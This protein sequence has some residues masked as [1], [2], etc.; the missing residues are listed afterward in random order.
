MANTTR[1]LGSELKV[2]DCIE[3]WFGVQRVI[4]LK[5]YV[6]GISYLFKDGAQLAK[7][8]PSNVGMTIDNG[9]YY[10]VVVSA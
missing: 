4:D 2:N 7:F 6:G 9:D 1:K 5:P 3:T 10:D 8:A